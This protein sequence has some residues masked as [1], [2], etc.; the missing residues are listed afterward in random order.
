[1]CQQ[2]VKE[3]RDSYKS[4]H[5]Y[6]QDESRFG[7]FTK[8]GRALTVKGVKPICPFQQVFKSTYLFGAFS[9]IT[10]DKFLLEY[11]NCNADIFELFLNELSK[12]NPIELKV[13][14]VDNAAFHKAKKIKIPDNIVL[15][16][17]PPYSPEV[18]PAEQIWAWYKRAF[19][20]RIYKSIPQ[21]VDFI[22]NKSENLT[23]EL[24]KSITRQE[25]I[26]S[27]Y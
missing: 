22:S 13:M 23:K 4:I 8:N 1:M 6:F 21:I 12:E 25:Y 18:N 24:V 26:F 14:V 27:N 9:P 16:F 5:L 2:A 10:G 7:M 17:Q 11:P 19:T 3:K 15:I 20:N